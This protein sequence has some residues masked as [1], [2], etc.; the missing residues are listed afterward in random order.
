MSKQRLPGLL[1]VYHLKSRPPGGRRAKKLLAA[2]PHF[3]AF[4]PVVSDQ[5]VG[6][7]GVLDLLRLQGWRQ[8]QRE[9]GLH[10]VVAVR[11]RRALAAGA[12]SHLAA[13]EEVIALHDEGLDDGLVQL[14]G[15][16]RVLVL[17][18]R[19][20]QRGP[21]ADRQ[22]ISCHQGGLAVLAHPEA[23][24]RYREEVLIYSGKYEEMK[25]I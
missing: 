22:V 11:R 13:V 6:V 7:Q 24:D 4:P 8:L 1:C 10:H 14:G 3:S 18:V 5:R 21:E 19:P 25:T 2:R 20:H 17:E 9:Q 15:G 12:L 16:Q 23:R